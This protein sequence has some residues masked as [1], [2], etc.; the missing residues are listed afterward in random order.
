MGQPFMLSSLPGAMRLAVACVCIVLLGGMAT[1]LQHLVWHHEN[2]DERPGL[3]VDDVR[4][5]YHGL[6]TTAPLLHALQRGHP[7]KLPEKSRATL[8]QW[9]QGTRVAEDFDNLDLGDTAP[10]E[11]IRRECVSCHGRANAG[12]S[13]IAKSIPLDYWD[14][15]KPVAFS[16]NVEPN[17]KKIIA[18]SMHTHALSLGCLT[19]VTAGLAWCTRWR[20]GAVSGLSLLAA[21]G[22]VVDLAGWWLARGAEPAVWGIVAGGGAYA[23]ATTL[24]ILMTLA[25]VVLPARR[26]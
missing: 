10:A 15:V 25:D 12:T 24:L 20:R 13:P 1:S 17:S 4:G 14:D 16:R 8:L 6:K 18:A 23:I 7:E 19:V 2:R 11:I 9:L 21:A 3:S 26:G 22:L 5:V